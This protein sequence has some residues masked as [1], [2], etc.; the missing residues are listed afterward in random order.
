MKGG[1]SWGVSILGT[2][3]S[4][5]VIELISETSYLPVKKMSVKKL[6]KFGM[7]YGFEHNTPVESGT[8]PEELSKEIDEVDLQYPIFVRKRSFWKWEVVDG[9]HR[10]EKSARLGIKKIAVKQITDD[11][12]IRINRYIFKG[13]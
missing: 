5:Y 7:F 13:E 3:Y 6:R 11:L 12:L 1:K 4:G 8:T 10:L 2:F 9:N